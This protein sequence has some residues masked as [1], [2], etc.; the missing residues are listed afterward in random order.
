MTVKGPSPLSR[1]FR[2]KDGQVVV[3]QRPNLP[4]LVWL[5]ATVLGRLLDAG[6]LKAVAV[7]ALAVW[8]LLEVASGASPFRRV[9]GGVVLAG[10]L[11]R[12][13]L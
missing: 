6:W 8:A 5:V 2:D 11:A 7:V 12:L 10:I 13:L 4:L 1:F 3:A 9:L